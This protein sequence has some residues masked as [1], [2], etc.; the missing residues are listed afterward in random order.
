MAV[1]PQHPSIKAAAGCQ[2]TVTAFHVIFTSRLLGKDGEFTAEPV[3]ATLPKRK[4]LLEDLLAP[5]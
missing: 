2:R 1:A 4:L 3:H 5:A